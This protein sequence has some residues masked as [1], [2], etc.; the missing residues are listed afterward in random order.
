MKRIIISISCVIV[1][2]GAIY[3]AIAITNNKKEN[4]YIQEIAKEEV[5]EENII[6]DCTEEYE[7]MEKEKNMV[8]ANAEEEEKVSPNCSFTKKTYY[9]KCGHTVSNYLEL[10]KDIV[11]LTKE[12]VTN[13]YQD[14]SIEEFASN[15]I[16]LFK[17]INDNCGEHYL[18]KDNEGKVTV[19]KILEDGSQKLFE[20]TDIYTEYLTDED[21]ENMKEGISINGKQELNQLIEDFE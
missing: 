9:T 1:V 12:Q 15:K 2:I 21:R 20:E 16:V 19:Y 13:K 18:V 10:P 5:I 6:D 4:N 3:I 7:E 17:Q 8:Q 14:Y 11:N